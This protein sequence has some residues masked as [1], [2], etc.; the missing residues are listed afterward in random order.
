V[1]AQVLDLLADIK[2]RLHLSML[3]VT[4]D[5][6]VALQVCDR[7]A[8]MKQGEVVEVAPTAEIFF[9]PQHPYTKALFAAVPG[10][11]WQD[12]KAS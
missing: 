11:S 3:F 8:V 1:Q 7:I 4:H 2:A 5:L 12:L 9:N 10:G 6:R